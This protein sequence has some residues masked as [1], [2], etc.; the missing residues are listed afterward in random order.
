[1]LVAE[2]RALGLVAASR[3]WRPSLLSRAQALLPLL[4]LHSYRVRNGNY[5]LEKHHWA[6]LYPRS[7]CGDGI[8]MTVGVYLELAWKLPL[9]PGQVAHLLSDLGNLCVHRF[10]MGGHGIY[11]GG[12]QMD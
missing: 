12:Q 1:M 4:P 8:N 5:L 10:L 2:G 3:R 7:N 11:P 9:R 6:L